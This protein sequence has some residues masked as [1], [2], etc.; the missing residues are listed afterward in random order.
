M[1]AAARLQTLVLTA[2]AERAR[3]FYSGVLGLRLVGESLG[4]LVYDVGGG[5]LRVSPVPAT[6]PTEHTVFGFAVDD[7]EAT[8]AGLA[9]RGVRFERFPAFPHDDR[10]IVTAPDGSRVAWFRDPDGNLLSVVR[11][12]AG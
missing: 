7:L 12:A 8:L 1:L 5:A 3:A 4:A 2:D 11:Y 6:Q 10:G 9:A